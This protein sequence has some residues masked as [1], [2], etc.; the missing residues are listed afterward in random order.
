MDLL[1]LLKDQMSD[2]V[3]DQLSNQIRS[4]KTQTS[5]AVNGIFS[6]LVT[7]L[8]KNA[9]SPNGAS[10]LLGALDRDHDGSVL[11]DI[12]GFVTAKQQPQQARANNGLGILDHV[13]GGNINNVIQMVSKSSGLD[14]LKTGQLMQMLAPMVMGALGKTKKHEN[15]DQ[16]G[17]TNL[18]MNTVKTASSQNKEMSLIS[19]I[20]DADG[21]GNVMD[22]IAGM[23][24]NV[25]GNLFKRR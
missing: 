14:F 16:G 13:L 18:L 23:G 12:L 21:D 17:I 1:N 7:A 2:S 20:L 10:A 11:D 3:V 6:T 22:D 9:A 15:L 4:D 25:L 8:S 19:K 24:M 5:A